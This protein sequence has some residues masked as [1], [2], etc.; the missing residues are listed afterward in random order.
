[1]SSF[2]EFLPTLN[3]CLNGCST[4]LL[5][6]GFI[7]IKSGREKAHRGCMVS[8][9]SVSVIFLFFYVLH[10]ILVKGV[11]TSFAGDGLWRDVYYIM[12]ATHIVLAMAIVPLVLT[13]LILALKDKREKHKAWAKWTFPIWYYVSVTGVLVYMFLYQWF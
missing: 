13:T 12:L 1:M 5:T 8:A 11:H 6:A 7:C 2:T 9:F 3:A 4:L 10:K